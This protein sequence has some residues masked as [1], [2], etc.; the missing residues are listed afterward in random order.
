LLAKSPCQT[1]YLSPIFLDTDS[2][3]VMGAG[4][5]ATGWVA[6]LY[7]PHGQFSIWKL[8]GHS[9]IHKIPNVNKSHFIKL[10]VVKL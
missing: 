10:R 2:K 5:G 1:L 9:E 8:A 7:V 6:R 3:S 4:K